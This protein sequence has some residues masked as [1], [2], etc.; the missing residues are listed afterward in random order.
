MSYNSEILCKNFLTADAWIIYWYI[1]RVTCD[2]CLLT[3]I[4]TIYMLKHVLSQD[5][6]VN[7]F[8]L[9][10]KISRLRHTQWMK[11]IVYR[12]KISIKIRW[13]LQR[14]ETLSF[15]ITG[16]QSEKFKNLFSGQLESVYVDHFAGTSKTIFFIFNN[17]F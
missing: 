8:G 5:L 17:S 10:L 4:R 2:M 9:I 16:W 3:N 11:S 7:Y 14:A 13:V 6:S 1:Y 12:K 15:K